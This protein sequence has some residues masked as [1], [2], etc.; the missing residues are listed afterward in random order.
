MCRKGARFGGPPVDRV[1]RGPLA[2]A[3]LP[4]EARG[5]GLLDAHATNPRTGELCGA[6]PH[7]TR[8]SWGQAYGF[9][10]AAWRNVTHVRFSCAVPFG[11]I[12]LVLMWGA[13]TTT[14]AVVVELDVPLL[15]LS[16]TRAHVPL[17]P[18]LIREVWSL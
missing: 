14:S 2:S 9:V 11:T 8:G 13:A 6:L 5:C 12:P 7:C 18:L 1:S 10:A 4:S 3:A 17:F 16:H 15:V